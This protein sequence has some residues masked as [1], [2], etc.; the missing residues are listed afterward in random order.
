LA[1][2]DQAPAGRER[3]ECGLGY[4]IGDRSQEGERDVPAGK[5]V[6]GQAVPA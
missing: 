1:I 4:G 6:E 5:G 2:V 3:R